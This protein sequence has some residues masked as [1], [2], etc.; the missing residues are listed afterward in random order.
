MLLALEVER[1]GGPEAGVRAARE[2]SHPPHAVDHGAAHAIVRERLERH[3]ARRIETRARLDQA[4]E[5][6]GDELLEHVQLGFSKMKVIY[7][8]QGKTGG[9]GG[10]KVEFETDAHAGA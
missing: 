4:L 9:A 5:S 1:L 7:T 10:G 2:V 3:A 6:E 8:P